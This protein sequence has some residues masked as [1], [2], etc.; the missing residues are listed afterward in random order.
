M[1]AKGRIKTKI[2]KDNLVLLAEV[3][4]EQQLQISSIECILSENIFTKVFFDDNKS[5]QVRKSLVEWENILPQKMFVRINRGTIIN[6][7]YVKQIEKATNRT[8]I[9]YMQNYNKPVVLSGNY[10]EKLKGNLVL[11]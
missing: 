1:T 10:L 7:Y 3:K 6:L 2:D 9:I 11:K 4:N 8:M 5:I